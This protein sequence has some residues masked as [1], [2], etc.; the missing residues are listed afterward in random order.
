M[1]T[2]TSLAE[3]TIDRKGRSCTYPPPISKSFRKLNSE[4]FNHQGG[5]RVQNAAKVKSVTWHGQLTGVCG[6]KKHSITPSKWIHYPLE[7]F[8]LPPRNS[9]SCKHGV[10]RS[11]F[12]IFI[13]SAVRCSAGKICCS[14]KQFEL[15]I[16]WHLLRTFGCPDT[17][18]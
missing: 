10:R 3:G 9:W 16:E 18:Q 17:T 8:L 11:F 15:I 2:C 6:L 12:V 5:E 13:T 4:N 7:M 1:L 14:T